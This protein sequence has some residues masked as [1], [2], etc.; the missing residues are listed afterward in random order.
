M[1]K[2]GDQHLGCENLFQHL[3]LSTHHHFDMSSIKGPDILF[4]CF[5]TPNM[6]W[7]FFFWYYFQYYIGVLEKT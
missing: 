6:V 5:W 2:S 4:V 3:K 1:W 7:F